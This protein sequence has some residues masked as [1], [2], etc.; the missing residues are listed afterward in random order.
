MWSPRNEPPGYV[1]LQPIVFANKSLTSTETQCSNIEREDLGIFH[2]LTKFH[3]CCSPC[4]VI[5]IT[6]HKLLEVIDAASSSQ[7]LQRILLISIRTASEYCT[8]LDQSHS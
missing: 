8:N 3:H 2:Y 5:V 7:R 4:E 6:D 1:A